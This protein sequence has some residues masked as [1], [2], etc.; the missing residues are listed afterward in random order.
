VNTTAHER[1]TLF[2]N[3]EEVEANEPTGDQEKDLA[4]ARKLLAENGIAGLQ[5]RLTLRARDSN[6]PRRQRPSFCRN[7]PCIVSD[8]AHA[9][10]SQPTERDRRLDALDQLAASLRRHIV[11]TVTDPFMRHVELMV[12][13]IEIERARCTGGPPRPP[14]S[15]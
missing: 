1:K 11:T 3:G 14:L 4:A 9:M 6:E 5:E 8:Q 15:G 10:A 13:E 12:L 7:S 2:L